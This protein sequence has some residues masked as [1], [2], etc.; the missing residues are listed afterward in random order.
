MSR[1]HPSLIAV[2]GLCP[3]AFAD[4]AQTPKTVTLVVAFDQRQA[5]PEVVEALKSE[6]AEIWRSESVK[7]DWRPLESIK[8]GDS[9]E[10]LVVVHFKGDCHV[11]PEAQ[12]Y[13]ID[14]RG[15]QSSGPFAYSVSVDGTVQ[16]FSSVLCER[17]ERSMHSA[18]EPAQRKSADALYG[19]ALGR[20]LSHELYHI[21]NQTR[22]HQ[23]EGLAKRALTGKQLIEPD[24]HF[25]EAGIRH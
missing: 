9:F 6:L 21:F 2:L 12:P 22:N 20:V 24:F 25:D 1:L 19:R 14:E 16:P 5:E 7:L 10:D 11:R 17:V 8:P 23:R 13:L 18:L 4:Q 3:L 15:P